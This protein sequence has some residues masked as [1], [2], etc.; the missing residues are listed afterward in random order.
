[1]V[2]TRPTEMNSGKFSQCIF[3]T[4]S[5]LGNLYFVSMCAKMHQYT[6]LAPQT[7]WVQEL[8]LSYFYLAV[9]PVA[10]SPLFFSNLLTK[11]QESKIGKIRVLNAESESKCCPGF[12][13]FSRVAYSRIKKCH[14]VFRG[15]QTDKITVFTISPLPPSQFNSH[16]YSGRAF[17]KHVK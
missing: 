13:V 16:S 10:L 6:I 11:I 4:C 17:T 9:S 2:S 15:D 14:S 3:N 5:C 8:Y 7:F 1:M 12:S